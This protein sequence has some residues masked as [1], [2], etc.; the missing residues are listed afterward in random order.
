MKKFVQA[1]VLFLSSMLLQGVNAG[2]RWY[3]EAKADADAGQYSGSILRDNFYSGGALLNVDY[4][5]IYSFAFA[6]N[7][8]RINF[9]NADADA[10]DVTQDMFS[11]RFQYNFY[12]DVLGGK[13][14]AQLVTHGI[15]NSAPA[16]LSGDILIFAP[17]ISYTRYDKSLSAAFEYTRSDYTDRRNLVI[18]QYAPSIGFGFNEDSDWL[19]FNAYLIQS[20]NK[21]LSQGEDSLLS[22]RI[23]W[24]HWF[25]PS[26]IFGVNNLYIDVLAGKRI[27]AVDNESFYIYNLEG[28]QQ[29]SVLLGLGWRPGENFYVDLIAGVEKFT[30]NVIIDNE[31]Y[32]QYLHIS[33][34]KHW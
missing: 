27:F 25:E 34:S 3:V 1:S 12:N 24:Q 29:E 17:K 19:Q 31:Y 14:T 32:R 30:N 16:I 23:K 26:T 22:A 8:L 33:L 10:Y 28:V 5:D 13:V 6:Y 7:H 20:S 2:E 15:T 21:L 9:K 4:I 11:G 18:Q